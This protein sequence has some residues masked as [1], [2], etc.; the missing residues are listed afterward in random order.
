MYKTIACNRNQY[1]QISTGKSIPQNCSAYRAVLTLATSQLCRPAARGEEEDSERHESKPP[2]L[3][4][5]R[6]NKRKKGKNINSALLNPNRSLELHGYKMSAKHTNMC[7]YVTGPRF[8][9]PQK[10]PLKSR[11]QAYNLLCR[12][13]CRG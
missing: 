12:H 11:V 10:T 5:T 6:K 2:D 4:I 9:D 13:I 1:R 7:H 3:M 8:F